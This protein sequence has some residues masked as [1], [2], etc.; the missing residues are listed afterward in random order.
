MSGSGVR[1]RPRVEPVERPE[2]LPLSY[3]QGR[4][5]FLYRFEG[6]SV[7]YNLPVVL[8]LWEAVDVGVM[9]VAVRDVVVRHE[10]LRTVIGEDERGVAFQRILSPDEV[11]VEV[12]S[13][14]VERGEVAGAVAEAVAYEFELESEIPIRVGLLEC[15]PQEFVLVILMHHIAGDA[16]SMAPL[17]RDLSVAYAARAAGREPG[18]APL[19][20]QYADYTLWQQEL[21]GEL[22]DPES[23]ESSQVAYWRRELAGAP[24]PLALPTD[25]PRPARASYRGDT[26][27][28]VIGA[29]TRRRGGAVGAQ[30]WCDGADGV[31]GGVCGVVVAVGC[32]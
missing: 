10:S 31:A 5:W 8:R 9:G 4:L 1:V 18:W 16:A 13:R 3:A 19:P 20:V 30:A 26:I 29:G 32:G 15:G 27:E 21:L 6:P 11:V 28:F 23:I 14:V 7:T 2:R 24:Q 12:A 17:A 22:S 25:R